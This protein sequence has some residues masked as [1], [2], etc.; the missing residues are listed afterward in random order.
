[1]ATPTVDTKIW[2]AIREHLETLVPSQPAEFLWPGENETVPEIG[3]EV[4]FFPNRPQRH[5]LGSAEP[6][7][8]Q[9]MLQIGLMTRPGAVHHETFARE[10]AGDIADHFPADHRMT[11]ANIVVRVRETP[12]PGPSFR[13]D[14][15]NRWITP[16]TVY[17]H[18]EA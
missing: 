7:Y 6:S 12:V 14:R 4:T 15:R 11:Y 9:G 13:D 18:T 2:L 17:W 5:Y 16:T 8:R 1:M 3:M 10:I